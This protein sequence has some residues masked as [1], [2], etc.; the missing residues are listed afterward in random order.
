MASQRG[1]LIGS[2]R[3]ASRAHFAQRLR[4]FTLTQRLTRAVK[5]ALAV[6]QSFRFG[7]REL[8]GSRKIIS[9]RLASAQAVV[10]VEHGTS[11]VDVLGEIFTGGEYE[12]PAP[13]GSWL[14]GQPAERHVADLGM[15]VGL[16]SL[17]SWLKLG[18][19]SITGAEPDARNRE[20]LQRLVRA[21]DLEDRVS[22]WA[23]CAS[24]RVGV[25]SFVSGGGWVSHIGEPRQLGAVETDTID[26][27]DH[28]EG[29]GLC[30]IDIEGG[31]WAILGDPRWDTI[32]VPVVVIEYHQ[33][34]C[35]FEVPRVAC[36]EALTRAGYAP[37]DSSTGLDHQGTIWA[38]KRDLLPTPPAA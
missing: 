9:Y 26:V 12:P 14:A 5:A 34:L 19:T 3:S 31:E 15:H 18:A 38:I 35:P 25:T 21:N 27:F 11:D 10:F 23:A 20:Q 2:L 16:F 8:A 17:Y 24:N 22:I 32:D 33:H 28:L 1:A 29:V 7:L 13:I 30:K 4:Q 37:F 6:K 36:A